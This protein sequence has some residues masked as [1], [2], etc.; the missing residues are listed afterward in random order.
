MFINGAMRHLG[1]QIYEQF[2]K[3][4]FFGSLE[5]ECMKTMLQNLN[6]ISTGIY[7]TIYGSTSNAI[8]FLDY[9]LEKVIFLKQLLTFDR[10]SYG[11]VTTNK[12]VLGVLC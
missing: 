4:I 3:L 2:S 1:C 12:V 6:E 7:F 8:N 5:A 9:F 10:M 11:V